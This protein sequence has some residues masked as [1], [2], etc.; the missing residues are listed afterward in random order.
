MRQKQHP[1]SSDDQ[2]RAI[3]SLETLIEWHESAAAEHDRTGQVSRAAGRR[4][5]AGE[6]RTTLNKLRAESDERP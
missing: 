5:M 6:L 1:L 4:G 2:A 3:A